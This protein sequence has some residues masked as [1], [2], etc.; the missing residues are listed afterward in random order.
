MDTL[1]RYLVRRCFV[2]DSL[3]KTNDNWNDSKN[4]FGWVTHTYPDDTSVTCEVHLIAETD[5][6]RL[7]KCKRDEFIIY[8]FTTDYIH[9][10]LSLHCIVQV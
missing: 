2:E 9:L 6:E 5:V 3:W 8:Q 7:N 1:Y 4:M 10:M